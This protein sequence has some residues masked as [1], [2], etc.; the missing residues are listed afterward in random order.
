MLET[1][2]RLSRS[3][4]SL[5]KLIESE[6]APREGAKAS[7]GSQARETELEPATQGESCRA[8][9][10]ERVERAG[11]EGEENKRKGRSKSEL[12]A[13]ESI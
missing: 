3:L 12:G 7:S 1:A 8:E 13:E 4:K 5:I 2:V 10:R 6:E 9:K 11:A